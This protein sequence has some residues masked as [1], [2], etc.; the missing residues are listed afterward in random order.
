MSARNKKVALMRILQ[1]VLQTEAADMAVV[2]RR[3]C[4]L[5]ERRGSG[6]DELTGPPGPVA[7]AP[8]AS[9]R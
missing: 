6:N 4:F 1:Y 5:L 7:N 9:V 2:A 3:E 8:R